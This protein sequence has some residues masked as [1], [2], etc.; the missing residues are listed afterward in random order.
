MTRMSW[1]VAV[2][3]VAACDCESGPAPIPKSAPILTESLAAASPQMRTHMRE[4]V[5]RADQL[6]A[7]I[8]Q[9][10]LADARDLAAWFATHE[11]DRP[12]GWGPYL[13]EMRYAA[14]RIQKAPD[15]TAAGAALGRFGASC[16]ACHVAT[17]AR[18]A[19]AY[20]P[21]P[22]DTSTIEA[23]MVRHE[24][25]AARL[26][27]GVVGPA[28]ALWSEGARVM[29]TARFDLAKL[30]HEKPNADVAALAEQL[31]EQ[32]ATAISLGDPAARAQFYGE[33]MQ[34]CASC[35]SIVR[36]QAVVHLE[37]RE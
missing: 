27:E 8:A 5:D 10:R 12:P 37:Q 25:A 16:A 6:Q 22:Q 34:T 23:Q 19:F 14:H 32:A 21:P 30:A 2:L 1:M 9:G 18:P 3:A 28:D 33:M 7:A 20:E 24:W 26:W 17:G 11:M 36:P 13:D 15:V 31:R 35:H 4:H 29:W